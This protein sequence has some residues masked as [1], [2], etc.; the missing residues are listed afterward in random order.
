MTLKFLYGSIRSSLLIAFITFACVILYDPPFSF[1][2]LLGALLHIMNIMSMWYVTF[3]FSKTSREW[4]LPLLLLKFP[5]LC[6]G[7]YLI[8]RYGGVSVLSFFSGFSLPL[9]VIILKAF[10]QAFTY[11]DRMPLTVYVRNY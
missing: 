6:G 11:R 10:S 4:I 9:G 1:G 3:I 5:L 8:I 2:F 7:A